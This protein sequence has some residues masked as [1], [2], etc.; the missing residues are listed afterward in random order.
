MSRLSWL[1]RALVEG[2]PSAHE[3]TVLLS[4]VSPVREPIDAGICPNP[5]DARRDFRGRAPLERRRRELE[6]IAFQL[7]PRHYQRN[8][9]EHK[10][11]GEQRTAHALEEVPSL[12]RWNPCWIIR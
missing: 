12:E 6:N 7:P 1:R 11:C 10:G 2:Q 3:G 5:A 8:R 9:Q 4:F